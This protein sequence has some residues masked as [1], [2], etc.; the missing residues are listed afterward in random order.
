MVIQTVANAALSLFYERYPLSILLL[1]FSQLPVPCNKKHIY[2]GICLIEVDYLCV[3]VPWSV[4]I[5]L[6][7]NMSK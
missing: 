1:M 5:K 3:Y 4:I 2:Y 7:M 6:Y